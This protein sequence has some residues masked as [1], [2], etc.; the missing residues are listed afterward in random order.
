M[1][2]PHLII[3]IVGVALTNLLY[4]YPYYTSL[5]V[6]DTSI[7]SAFFSFGKIIIPIFAF[8][9]VGELLKVREY[10]GIAIIIL[11]NILLA[12]HQTKSKIRLSKAFYLIL[13]ASVILATDGVLF[14]YMFDHGVT[15]STAV[16]G[17]LLFSGI[18]G[19]LFLLSFKK[20][21]KL[22]FQDKQKY[23]SLGG[24][25]FVEEL[26]TFLAIACETYAI[27]LA[28]VSLVKSVGMTIPIFILSYTVVVKR[29][30]PKVFHENT[31]RSVFIKKALVF[32]LIIAG[33]ILM[34]F[35]D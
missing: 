15:W 30:K 32:S 21:R 3:P 13:L 12:F 25:F 14:K 31:H 34:G 17:Q 20:T 18:F 9:F 4:L 33:L 6:E 7:V 22:I 11:G 19:V 23:R 10:I 5:K 27:S 16:G 1:P 24:L 2:S 29:F 35:K 28:P 8:V 26:F